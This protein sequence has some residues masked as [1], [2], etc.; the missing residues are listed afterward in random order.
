MGFQKKGEGGPGI[1]S[2]GKGNH[3]P[4]EL[5]ARGL[6][7]NGIQASTR[8]P[9]NKKKKLLVEQ[10]EVWRLKSQVICLESGDKNTKFFQAFAKG[11]KTQNTIWSLQNEEN[12]EFTSFEG[13]TSLSTVHFKNLFKEENRS[14]MAKIIHL[15]QFLPRLITSEDI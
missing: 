8:L 13:L 14:N 12:E 15:S 4:S 2:N 11:M 9:R 6:C 5:I 7:T 10:E 1:D 3:P